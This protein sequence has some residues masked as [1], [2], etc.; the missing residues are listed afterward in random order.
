MTF[1]F[2]GDLSINRDFV[3][4]EVGDT[5][6]DSAWLTDELIASLITKHGS[7]NAA[8]ISALKYII[9]QLSRPDFRADW[10]QVSNAE[11]RKGYET[12]LAD[13]KKEY[14]IG[15][16]TASAVYTYRQDSDM[17]DPN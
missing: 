14:G 13:K 9:T 16:I 5:T 3:R 10:L 12:M 7:A 6:E 4:F 15:G 2:A 11:A 8:V 1:T 17:E